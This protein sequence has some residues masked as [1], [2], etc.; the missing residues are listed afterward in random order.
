MLAVEAG[1]YPQ[2]LFK[3]STKTALP[4]PQPIPEEAQVFQLSEAT[5][6]ER[7]GLLRRLPVGGS[8]LGI[9]GKATKS[10]LPTRPKIEPNRP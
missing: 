1:A 4:S 6:V 7:F 9:Y 2:N 10:L 8:V 3:A 5:S